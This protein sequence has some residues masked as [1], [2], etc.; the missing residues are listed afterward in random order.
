MIITDTETG[1]VVN[2]YIVK[3]DCGQRFK[4]RTDRYRVECPTCKA[5][6]LTRELDSVEDSDDEGDI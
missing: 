2:L 6:A 4:S 1:N 5:T 3:C